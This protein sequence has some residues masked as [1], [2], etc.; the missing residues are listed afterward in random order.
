MEARTYYYA[1]VSTKE[2]KL[3]RQLEVFK[4]MGAEERQI[5]VDKVS[6]K[7]FDRPGYITLKESLL[8][9]GDTLVV[10]EL[11]RLGRNKEQIKDE[12][13][14]FQEN[15]IR[16]RIFDI[17]TTMMDVPPD[18][19]WIIDMITNLLIEV[20]ASLAEQELNKIKKRQAEGIAEARKQG[21]NL[22]RKEI[23]LPANWEEVY[24]EWKTGSITAVEA[25]RKTGLKKTTFYKFVSEE[26]YQDNERIT[27]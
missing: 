26:E 7:N 17:P 1:R 9:P 14:Y 24:R 6:G 16:V 18:S 25:M 15:H 10:K 21:R 4:S 2:Q 11:D 19:Q 5:I 12:L 3:D 8:R 20:L 27:T 22:G 23:P 13:K